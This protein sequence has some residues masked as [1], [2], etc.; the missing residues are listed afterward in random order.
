MNLKRQIL[1]AIRQ[2]ILHKNNILSCA[3]EFIH[4][5]VIQVVPGNYISNEVVQIKEK[6][7]FLGIVELIMIHDCCV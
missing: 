2:H 5:L 6:G 1:W 4:I 3:R 7:L